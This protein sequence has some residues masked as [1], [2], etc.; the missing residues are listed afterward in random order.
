MFWFGFSKSACLF[1]ATF[2]VIE[3]FKFLMMMISLCISVCAVLCQAFVILLRICTCFP[4][5]SRG[6][7]ATV[8]IKDTHVLG[9]LSNTCPQQWWNQI[10][11]AVGCPRFHLH[12][13]LQCFSCVLWDSYM[14]HNLQSLKMVFLWQLC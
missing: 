7:L 8:A 12:F 3:S 10:M 9:H 2:T 1:P 11:P 14:H 13:S 4:I 6:L 5:C